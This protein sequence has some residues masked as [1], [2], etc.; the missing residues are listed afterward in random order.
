MQTFEAKSTKAPKPYPH[1]E[2]VTRLDNASLR[3]VD[4][5]FVQSLPEYEKKSFLDNLK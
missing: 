2:I 3:F 4:V 1:F 5:S